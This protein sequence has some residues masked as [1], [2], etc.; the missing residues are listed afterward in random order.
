MRGLPCV[1]C[2]GAGEV[3][4]HI[5]P[6]VLEWL[7]GTLSGSALDLMDVQAQCGKCSASQG[8]SL[9]QVTKKVTKGRLHGAS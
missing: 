4:D 7:K 6:Y 8:G 1:D 9:S 2:G 3:A 5:R